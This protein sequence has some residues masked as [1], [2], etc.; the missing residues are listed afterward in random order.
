[1]LLCTMKIY[2]YLM[3]ISILLCQIKVIFTHD[4]STQ[5]TPTSI[6]SLPGIVDDLEVCQGP[7]AVSSADRR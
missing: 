6:L 5:G 4:N 1:M 2:D 3:D 7:G